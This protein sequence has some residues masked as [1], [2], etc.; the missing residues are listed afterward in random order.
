MK[1][2]M[3][4]D[5]NADVV[6]IIDYCSEQGWEQETR[7]FDEGLKYIEEYDPDIIVLDLQDKEDDSFPGTS[8]INCIW[9]KSFRPVCVFSGQIVN[10]AVEQDKFPSPLVR[11]VDKGDESPVKEYL[12]QIAPY[13]G[14]IRAIQKSIREAFRRS[15][16]VFE[17][18]FR[19][20]IK[21]ENVIAYLCNSRMRDSFSDV[22][23]D[24]AL[25]AW[26][27]Y[28]YPSLS[29]NLFTGDVICLQKEF[30]DK[31]YNERQYYV[32]LS[33]SCDIINNNLSQ[34]VVAKCSD[35]GSI[36]QKLS[37]PCS[38]TKAM[39][40][41]IGILNFGYQNNYFFLPSFGELLPNLIVDMK[42]IST[43]SKENLSNYSKIISLSSPYRERLVWAYMQN[44]CRP[45][46]PTL[47]VETWA[48]NII[49]DNGSNE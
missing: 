16:D 15:F 24:T 17:L 41:L 1:V 30:K 5:N 43:I 35:T 42:D 47:D 19:D 10:S 49:P 28:I 34:I 48:K 45:G 36:K 11:F 20:G 13:A 31:A 3:I 39:D 44:A 23:K 33:Q 9:D 18:I 27:Q 7:R 29:E 38:V 32:V 22:L 46:V 12:A 14:C 8:I 2:L 6:G 21:N 37:L 26:C 25:P 40:R 4:E